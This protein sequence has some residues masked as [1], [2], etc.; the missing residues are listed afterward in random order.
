MDPVLD[1]GHDRPLFEGLRDRSCFSPASSSKSPSSISMPESRESGAME[2]TKEL[3]FNCAPHAYLE[4]A[5][6][7]L[8]ASAGPGS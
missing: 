8:E 7:I 5:S 6:E 1:K 2:Q 4:I 3:F